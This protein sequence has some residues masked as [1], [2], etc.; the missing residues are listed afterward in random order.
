M[1]NLFFSPSKFLL[2]FLLVNIQYKISFRCRTDQIF[3]II[4]KGVRS[5]R[6]APRATTVADRCIRLNASDP[7][8]SRSNDRCDSS[9]EK[10]EPQLFSTSPNVSVPDTLHQTT[11]TLLRLCSFIR[12]LLQPWFSSRKLDDLWK[13][14]SPNRLY[15][16]C[17]HNLD[18]DSIISKCQNKSV[19]ASWQASPKLL[20]PVHSTNREVSGFNPVAT[21]LHIQAPMCNYPSSSTRICK[22]TTTTCLNS[23]DSLPRSDNC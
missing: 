20:T 9:T 8:A 22:E 1:M 2:Q 14:V 4:T 21:A 15:G 6:F 19:Q 12:F 10:V 17:L 13:E 5:T 16:D 3:H 18:P 7:S 23:S 11:V